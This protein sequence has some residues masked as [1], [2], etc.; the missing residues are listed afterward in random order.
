MG[1]L[2][3]IEHGLSEAAGFAKGVGE[4][5]WEGVKGTVSGVGHLAEDG[6]KLATDSQYRKQ[7][8]SSAVNDAKATANFAATAVTDPGKAADEI[9]NT[10]SHAWNALETAYNQAAARGQGGEFIG[11]IFGQGAVFLG[12]AAIPGG[13]EADAVGAIG[14][15]GRATA[16]LGD[17]GKLGD[18]TE[19]VGRIGNLTGDA[20]KVA[21]ATGDAGEVADATGDAGK[22]ADAAKA[23][24][25]AET[26]VKNGYT[27]T[28]DAEGR[29]THIEGDLIS[30][31]AQ[32]RSRV[33]Q[34][35]AGG[36]D[37]LTTDEG[38]HFI[39]RRFDGPLENFN[40]FAQDANFNRGAYKAVENE[41]QRALD[42]GSSV[43][44]DIT[45]SYRGDSL[46]PQSIDVTY[47][48][49]GVPHE[50]SFLNRS[51]GK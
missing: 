49:D 32:G 25:A 22:V 35:A 41:W 21:D 44:V 30:N 24:G 26:V 15:A 33:A 1:L 38:G 23:E 47:T 18:A 50:T 40:H 28:L 6:Y 17:A 4:G 48:I 9:G 20:G 29:T 13:A 46:R 36:K 51:G 31:S 14:D 16:L 7:V 11:Q 3:S 27:Y 10:A 5:A 45:A 37:R 43:K 12:T 39:G 42:R 2:G 19:T 34:L 8:W